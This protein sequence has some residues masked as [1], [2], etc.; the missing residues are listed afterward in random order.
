[1]AGQGSGRTLV[2][3]DSKHWTET[4][5]GA[6]PADTQCGAPD[7]TGRFTACPLGSLCAPG[8]PPRCCVLDLS[9]SASG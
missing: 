6:D 9:A 8:R 1:M 5:Q 4:S 7:L 2:T 3:R